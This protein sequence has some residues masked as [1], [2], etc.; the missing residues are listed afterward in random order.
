[1]QLCQKQLCILPLSS[2]EFKTLKVVFK[3]CGVTQSSIQCIFWFCDFVFLAGFAVNESY[4]QQTQFP[5]VQQLQDS[6]TLES[7]AL[8]TS[9]HPPSLLQVPNTDAINVVS[10]AR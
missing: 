9:Y 5:A 6:S 2:E 7:Q 1:M 3:K 10:T 8:S 4:N